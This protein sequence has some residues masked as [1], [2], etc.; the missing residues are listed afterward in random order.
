MTLEPNRSFDLHAYLQ[1]QREMI[2]HA[3]ATLVPASEG[4]KPTTA[5]QAM[6]ADAFRL[7]PLACDSIL[8]RAMRHSLLA[9]GKRLRPILCL[10]A[11]EAVGGAAAHVMPAACALE[12][13]HTYSLIHDDLPALD[14]DLLRRGLPT[15]HSAFGEATAILAGDALLTRAFEVL[16]AAGQA[17][18]DRADRW[19]RVI[20]VVGRAAGAR[21]MVEGQVQDLAAEGRTL[22]LD[23][24]EHLHNLKTGALIRVAVYAGATLEGATAEELADLDTYARSLGLA[25]QI[26]DDILNVEGDSGLMGKAV[27][28]DQQRGKNTYP[29]L[30]SLDAARRR[31]VDLVQTGI[32]AL[33]RFDSSAAPLRALARYILIRKN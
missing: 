20:E 32:E 1:I 14:N 19:L 18:A 16:A 17:A 8:V 29:A 6:R 12:L 10:A 25:F 24:L 13:I 15:C 28:T 26:T 21:G 3:L 11:A 9:S 23:T 22:S 7:P 33:Q 30:I 4:V 2:N 31:A 5:W 27:G